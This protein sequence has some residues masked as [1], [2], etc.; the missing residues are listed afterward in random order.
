MLHGFKRKSQQFHN[1]CFSTSTRGQSIDE[2]YDC[3]PNGG[4]S[5]NNSTSARRVAGT[6]ETGAC[7]VGATNSSKA[8]GSSMNVANPATSAVSTGAR[9]S[10][11][12]GV[13]VLALF[14]YVAQEAD[15]LSFQAGN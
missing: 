1:A 9:P 14:D 2:W 4:T 5:S 13:L 6:N 10:E 3:N 8:N 15:E 12:E 7:S 11:S